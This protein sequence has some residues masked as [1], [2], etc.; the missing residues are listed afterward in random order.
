LPDASIWSHAS[1]AAA[2]AGSLAEC[3]A[4]DG[5]Y[6]THP[7]LATFSFSPIQ[8]LI[9]AS[10]KMRDFWA[11]SWL[12]HYLSACVCWKLAQKYGPDSFI[13]PSLYQ[14]PLIDLWLSRMLAAIPRPSDRALLTAGFPN[15]IVL[16]LPEKRVEMAMQN[17]HQTLVSEEWLDSICQQAFSKLR[18][19][20]LEERDPTWLGWLKSQWQTYWVAL[21]IG[22][23]N[24]SNRMS[25]LQ[26]EPQA[27][28]FQEWQD[29][30]N[31]ICNLKQPESTEQQLEAI[32]PLFVTEEIAFIRQV[33]DGNNNVKVNIGSWWPYVFDQ[34]RF[35]L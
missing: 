7:H 2:I 22:V 13:Y 27:A 6:S 8:E 10:R 31:R 4:E 1:I 23:K 19:E 29:E 20:Q 32:R 30:N 17:A 34:L 14:Q 12:L 9:K 28:D 26:K 21:P 16:L 3:L 35:S 18:M 11:G 5:S 33:A 15:V 24:S 25:E